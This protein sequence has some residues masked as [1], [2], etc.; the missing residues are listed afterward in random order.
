M[1][2]DVIKLA[3]RPGFSGSSAPR[4][5]GEPAIARSRLY[6]VF[7]ALSAPPGSRHARLLPGGG[8]VSLGRHPLPYDYDLQ[9]VACAMASWDAGPGEDIRSEYRALFE[10]G[11]VL[12]INE[13]RADMVPVGVVQEVCSI[14]GYFGFRP[15]PDRDWPPDH[16]AVEL[17]FMQM[18]AIKEALAD[19]D[20]GASYVLAQ[21]Q[22]LDR[23]LSR[24][25]PALAARVQEAVPGGF[26]AG[27]FQALDLFLVADR[28]WRA[29]HSPVPVAH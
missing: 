12:A 27:L 25:F 29:G 1:S 26:Y 15:N 7:A 24:W 19:Q 22:F 2:T 6:G 11:Q 16:L 18:M 28:R 5:S 21:S 10:S 4:E 13:D 3:Q 14:Y 23:H 8:L 9:P 17:E 20:S